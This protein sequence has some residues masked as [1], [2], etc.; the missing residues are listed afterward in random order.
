MGISGTPPTI[1]IKPELSLEPLA[2]YYLRRA[3]SYRFVRAVITQMFGAESLTRMHRI[4]PGR[5]V[6]PNLDQ[7]I[8]TM[9]N[10]F[11]GAYVMACRQLGLPLAPG[12]DEFGSFDP[13]HAFQLFDKWQ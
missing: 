3:E 4:A 11:Y 8:E 5:K 13:D 2:T 6:S 7:E 1:D 10:L 12:S 9:E